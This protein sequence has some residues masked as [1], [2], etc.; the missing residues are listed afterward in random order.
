MP[1]RWFTDDGK[2]IRQNVVD[3]EPT[4]E[5]VRALREINRQPMSDS[6][7]VATIPAEIYNEWLKEAGVAW[8]DVHAAR[9]VVRKKLL[10]GDAAVFRVHGGTF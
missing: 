4:I 7:H 5:R 10:S 1:E 3:V 8:D 2:L 6:W 9:E